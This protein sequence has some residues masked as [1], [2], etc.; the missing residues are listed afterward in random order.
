GGSISWPTIEDGFVSDI[1][2][3]SILDSFL[4]LGRM[5]LSSFNTHLYTCTR[6]PQVR[7]SQSH[8]L[9]ALAYVEKDKSVF[10]CCHHPQ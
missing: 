9:I 7:G 4:V 6:I 1:T 2:W 3:C 8:H 5:A 10:I